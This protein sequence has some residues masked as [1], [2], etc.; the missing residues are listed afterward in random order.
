[1]ELSSVELIKLVVICCAALAMIAGIILVFLNL[2][3][4]GHGFGPNSLKALGL[5][6]FLPTLLIIA[7]ALPDF[8]PEVLSTLLG[9]VA[10]YVLS[11][12]R[13]DEKP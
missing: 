9:T 7:V 13:Q 2:H 3:K 5:V 10:G 12:S 6:S 1:M 4:N 11:N 8:K